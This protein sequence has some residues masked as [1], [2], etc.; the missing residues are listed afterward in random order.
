MYELPD[1]VTSEPAR[2]PYLILVVAREGDLALP[3]FAMPAGLSADDDPGLLQLVALLG[4]LTRP[5][6]GEATRPAHIE[7]ADAR[8]VAA[9]TKTM[10][11]VGVSV[12]LGPCA[13]LCELARAFDA[14]RLSGGW[15]PH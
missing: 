13:R 15:Q 1:R 14:Q 8:F 9:I 12:S 10:G 7:C 3:V 6:T 4:A 11:D 5:L 2:I